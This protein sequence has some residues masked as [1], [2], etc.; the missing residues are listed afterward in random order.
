MSGTGR[1]PLEILDSLARSSQTPFPAHKSGPITQQRP[2]SALLET[3][4]YPNSD[5]LLILVTMQQLMATHREREGHEYFGRLS[6][7]QP[8]RRALFRALQAVMQARIANEV[9]L[10]RR[11][12]W[13][14][15]A[16]RKLDEGAAAEPLLGRL[17]RGLVFS[18]L[19]HRFG[20]TRQAVED[21][22]A[23]LTHA[24]DIPL[25]LNRGIYRGLA[26]AYR[27]LGDERRSRK[28]LAN[29]GLESL[30]DPRVPRVLGDISVDGMRGFRFGIR[31]MV[32][33]AY[34]VYVAEGYDF[35]NLA[36]VIAPDFI[37]AIDAGTTEETARE[38]V[39]DLR[40][41]TEAPIKYIILTHG[42]WD[43]A[44]G[45]AAVRE[46]GSTVIAHVGFPAELERSRNYRSPFR[47]FFGTGT[48]NL[49][50]RPDLLIS[51][52]EMISDGDLDLEVFPGKSGETADALFVR[53]KRHDLLFVGDAF[54]PYV[55]APFVAEGSPEG[56][57]GAVSMVLDLHPRR[58]I[59]GHIPLTQLFTIDAM[60][61]LHNAMEELYQRSLAAARAARPLAEVLHDNFLPDSLRAAPAAVQ[62]YL[63][64][65]DTFVQR[66]YAEHAGYWQSN[67]EG[68][69]VFTR[70]EWAQALD[71]LGGG[72]DSSFV[73]A[74][75]QLER[76]GDAGMALQIA[77]LGL[78]RY[79]SSAAL[80]KSRERVLTTLQEIYSQMN[81][82]RFIVYS[83]LSG[84]GLNP[85]EIGK[86]GTGQT[87][88]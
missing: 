71:L 55:G 66:V 57:L 25:G 74:V 6:E 16:I 53:D 85:L 2:L 39:S 64:V 42:H 82:F 83:E 86:D 68:I 27:T 70:A 88:M 34:N 81:P 11:A 72:S 69:D 5:I 1:K 41:I 43:H 8:N 26:A 22:E 87:G 77:E 78:V 4:A 73:R 13:V 24:A 19:P 31:R 46:P 50:A 48:M 61:G 17:A 76:R 44:G 84:R 65:R 45:L 14:Q 59:H 32:R 80:Q 52:P 49:E 58:L 63:I 35:A 23:C 40:K 47:Y 54:M 38:A 29:T 10:L 33:E 30:D 37:V 28:M 20:K 9:P 60:S 62:P 67:G 36:F 12:A 79:P 51:G 56:Y 3:A 18:E 7:E 15:D 75:K 21:L